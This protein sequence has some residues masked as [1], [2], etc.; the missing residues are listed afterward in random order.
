MAARRADPELHVRRRASILDAAARVFAQKGYSRA[1]VEDIAAQAGLGKSTIY[2]YYDDKSALFTALFERFLG[3]MT[4]AFELGMAVPSGGSPAQ[5]LL[6]YARAN[7]ALIR[8]SVEFAPLGL[9]FYSASAT[10]EARECFVADFS[11]LYRRLREVVAACIREGCERGEFRPDVADSADGL[12]AAY[13]GAFDGLMLQTW[14]DERF[15]V[16]AAAD[17]LMR[18]LVAGM[19]PRADEQEAP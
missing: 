17:A 15:D 18:T 16:V 6:D 3:E 10:P 11:E 5:T 19:R 12:A 4:D 7:A 1:R 2:E 9:E 8:E 14:F 13:V